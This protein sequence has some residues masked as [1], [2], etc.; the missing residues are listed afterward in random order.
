MILV[1][2]ATG[3]LGHSL[4]PRLVAEGFSVRALVRPSSDTTFLEQ[5]G[6]ELAYADDITDGEAV[7]RACLGCDQIVHAAGRFRFWGE[8]QAFW[9]TNVE[10][11]ATVLAA[12]A[13]AE[14]KRFVYIST[15]A[16]VGDTTGMTLV[17]ETSPCRP[18]EP[19]QQT[20]WEAERRVLACFREEG[21]PAVILR[22]GAYYGPWG[23]YAFNRLFFEE[24]LR[25]WRIKVNHGR[26]IT[27]PLF[28][29][30]KA[31]AIVLALAKGRPGEI[32]NISGRSID[33]STANAIVSELAGISHWRLN[34]PAQPVVLLARVWTALS[35]YTHRE[36][37]YPINM[38]SYVF[39]DWNISIE[40]AESELGFVPTPFEVGAKK[41]L[42][43]YWEQG[44]LKRRG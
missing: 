41:T 14:V 12:A 43:W 38:A 17:D 31:E 13:A 40:K 6:V 7:T 26:Y 19:Y 37:F 28:V 5:L 30:D 1:T 33:H 44:L 20:K 11:T 10:G 36:P 15:V 23:R 3:F 35:R 34:V 32:Y 24:P 9:R 22:P 21:L 42:E 18:Q 39:Q 8:P 29:S 25:G 16:V 2:G 27:F 4:T